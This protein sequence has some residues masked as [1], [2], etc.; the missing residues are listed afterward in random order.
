LFGKRFHKPFCRAVSTADSPV[1]A[2]LRRG[3]DVSVSSV[4]AVL[5]HG[6]LALASAAEDFQF[7]REERAWR[8]T[9][10]TGG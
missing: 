4:S 3:K 10:V 8:G 9:S 2:A 1:L 6:R 5:P 7:D